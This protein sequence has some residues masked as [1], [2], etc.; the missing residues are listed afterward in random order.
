[1]KCGIS[2][3]STYLD[4]G[5][6]PGGQC[7]NGA[8]VCGMK[9]SNDLFELLG[10]A[11]VDGDP[12]G[13]R[14]HVML[15]RQAGSDRFVADTVRQQK[16]GHGVAVQIAQ[17]TIRGSKLDITRAQGVRRCP[18]PTVHGFG[19]PNCH[20]FYRARGAWF[21]GSVG[22]LIDSTHVAGNG[23]ERQDDGRT[24]PIVIP[25]FRQETWREQSGQD[26][27]G[28]IHKEH[29]APPWPLSQDAAENDTGR[30]PA[31]GDGTP[32]TKCPVTF[33]SLGKGDRE[34]GECGGR[35]A[36]RLTVVRLRRIS[37]RDGIRS[38]SSVRTASSA[39]TRGEDGGKQE[40]PSADGQ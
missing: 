26:S 14:E 36:E 18:L 19:D 37:Q 6:R 13:V 11:N 35:P 29:P 17:L 34:N 25:T 1:M 2:G 39:Q 20:A 38:T 4:V 24:R 31:A 16:I 22:G 8:V 15:V 27:D 32:D 30:D 33:G 7:N 40:N 28:H 21:Q 5:L 10:P 3:E 12:I 23:Q 9:Q